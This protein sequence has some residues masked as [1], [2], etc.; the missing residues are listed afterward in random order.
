MPDCARFHSRLAK[1]YSPAP[2]ARW[3][4][5]EAI[6]WTLETHRP[7]WLSQTSLAVLIGQLLSGEALAAEI[8]R[9]LQATLSEPWHNALR[10]QEAEEARHIELLSRY[11]QRVEINLQTAGLDSVFAVALD[12]LGNPA[13]LVLLNNIVLESEALALYRTTRIAIGCPLFSAIATHIGNDESRHIRLGRL[14]IKQ[15]LNAVSQDEQIVIFSWIKDLWWKAGRTAL[16]AYG[17]VDFSSDVSHML[18]SRW[19]TAGGSGVIK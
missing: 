19:Q 18:E 12:W 5:D 6:D 2:R 15:T 8:C 16:A 14:M 17:D 13:A 7:F 4:A 1:L 11:A 10:K 3:N 9:R